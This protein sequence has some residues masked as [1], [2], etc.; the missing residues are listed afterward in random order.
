MQITSQSTGR[1]ETLADSQP[2]SGK[3]GRARNYLESL[4]KDLQELQGAR[5]LIAELIQNADDAE[6]ATRARFEVTADALTVWNDARF[7]QCDDIYADECSGALNGV[8]RCD[9]H[10]FRDVA[11]AW[12]REQ[13]DRTGAFGI[14]FTS[15][16]Q[17]TDRPVLLS[18]GWRWEIDESQPEHERITWAVAEGTRGTTFILPWARVDS[19]MRSQ[20]GQDPVTEEL[21]RQLGSE[22]LDS[23]AESLLFLRRV[24]RIDVVV[25]GEAVV[26]ERSVEGAVRTVTGSDGTTGRWYIVSDSFSDVARDLKKGEGDQII[27]QGRSDTVDVAIRLD[28]PHVMGRYFVTLPTNEETR[29]PLSVNASFFPH[30]DRKRILVEQSRLGSWNRAIVD[31]AAKIVASKLDVLAEVAGDRWTVEF[32]SAVDAAAKSGSASKDWDPSKSWRRPL[33]EALPTS[34]VV[35]TC[36]GKRMTIGKALVWSDQREFEAAATLK[37]LD[38]H[39]VHPNVGADWFGLR[40][41]GVPIRPLHL[42]DVV[43]ALDRRHR[44]RPFSPGG[45]EDKDGVP[46]WAL[47]DHQIEVSAQHPSAETLSVL[48][49]TALLPLRTGVYGPASTSRRAEPDTVALFERAGLAPPLVTLDFGRDYP[50]LAARAPVVGA[51]QMVNWFSAAFLADEIRP[52]FDRSELLD[53]L[54]NCDPRT[55]QV[56]HQLLRSLPIYPV[57]SGHSSLGPGVVLPADGFEEPLRLASVLRLE[58]RPNNVVAFLENLGVPSLSL[59]HYFASLLRPDVVDGLGEQQLVD[60]LGFLRHHHSLIEQDDQVRQNLSSLRLVPCV[61]G[62]RRAGRE[63]Y[64]ASVET[65]LVGARPPR[66]STDVDTQD[67]RGLLSWLGVSDQPRPDDL[68]A[69]CHSLRRP[70]TNHREVVVAVLKHLSGVGLDGCKANYSRLQQERWLPIH[71]K[72]G[73]AARPIDVYTSVRRPIF[74]SQASFLDVPQPIEKSSAQVLKWL[75]VRTDPEPSMVVSHLILCARA[76]VPVSR[77]LWGFLSENRD[78]RELNH[79]KATRCVPLGDGRYVEPGSCF[80]QKHPFG[81][82][83]HRLDDALGEWRE[84]LSQLGVR[85][86]PSV[87][88]AVDVLGEVAARHGGAEAPVLSDDRDVILGT[89]VFL[90][91]LLTRGD[92][93]AADFSE[94]ATIECVLDGRECLRRPRDVLFRDSSA[95]AKHFDDESVARLIDR[96]ENISEALEAAG[97]RRLRHVV[98]TEVVERRDRSGRSRFADL[99]AE[100][101]HL[102]M[103]SLRKEI[104]DPAESL[105]RFAA[106]AEVSPLSELVVVDRVELDDTTLR[107]AAIDRSALWMDE[108]HCF[109][110]IEPV[111]R[112]PEVA[113]EFAF[114][115]TATSGGDPEMIAML[116]KNVLAAKTAEEAAAELDGYGFAEIDVPVSVS[117]VQHTDSVSAADLSDDEVLDGLSSVEHESESSTRVASAASVRQTSATPQPTI[118][119]D[120]VQGRPEQLPEQGA[121]PTVR[122]RTGAIE[123]T[124]ISSELQR[125][126]NRRSRLKSYVTPDPGTFDDRTDSTEARQRDEIERAAV[127]AVLDY[128]IRV[129]RTPREMP[130]NNPGFDIESTDGD[131]CRRL[132]EVKGTRG[133]W[134]DMGVGLTS[135]EFEEARKRGADYWLYV[136][137]VGDGK[138][139]AIHRIQ[140]P[141][142]RIDRYFF[143]DGWRE[144][145]TP[146]ELALAPLPP[147]PNLLSSSAGVSVVR[148]LDWR[149]GSPTGSFIRVPDEAGLSSPVDECFAIQLAGSAL[150]RGT[151]GNVALAVAAT[152]ARTGDCV[153]VRLGDRIDADTGSDMCVR[154][155]SPEVSSDPGRSPLRLNSDG[156]V[157]PI[158]LEDRSLVTVLGRVVHVMTPDGHSRRL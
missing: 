95:V 10:S 34:K 128:E 101:R 111:D 42:D 51:V 36:S 60:L 6:G 104:G 35:P 129:G 131:G 85:D 153:V 86:Q 76:G 16:Y 94:L 41:A 50:N 2:T 96:P 99:V 14:G 113:K 126:F 78:A 155:W 63:V 62:R 121:K 3:T 30:T 119:G 108:E 82:Y 38:V 26:F 69:H 123:K 11:G 97:V 55:L 70:P 103:R 100:R 9:F 61:D 144:V 87:Q 65:L 84:L 29:L 27:P 152:D 68:I 17:I 21:V 136:V 90:N 15:V 110:V 64:F 98:I 67:L 20:L 19:L 157:A 140:N 49:R 80:W 47:I 45:L 39:L 79:L 32:L 23:T 137:E 130:A 145:V 53:W 117:D 143:D 127:D 52:D 92:A 91:E 149:T 114:A 93:I 125:D 1:K 75:G 112:W 118:A 40:N 22:L 122:P 134:D 48:D 83:R 12:K 147:I 133:Q 54:A 73:D 150:G 115:L 142:E 102:L 46:L 13:R 77:D 135:N 148:L 28:D 56:N 106:I 81:R 158:S 7:S 146:S 109:L 74:E 8:E 4:R 18:S 107:T 132:I 58:G 138:Q 59:Q 88:D 66:V 72:P 37:K 31:C 89:W 57:G 116:V 71:G 5:A 124:T 151:R 24:R 156:A 33:W 154:Y 43:E 44:G 141:A 120:P 25:N 139:H 105:D